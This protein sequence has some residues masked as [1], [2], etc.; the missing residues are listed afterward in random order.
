MQ[1]DK[2]ININ[3]IPNARNGACFHGEVWV[4][5]PHC[6]NSIEVQSTNEEYKE[7]GYRVYKCKK[8]NRYFKDK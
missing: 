6:D 2:I 3:L 7:D 4:C 8:C 5:C 1:K